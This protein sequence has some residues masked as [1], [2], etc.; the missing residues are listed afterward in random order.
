MR[1][2]LKNLLAALSIGAAAA[3]L[4][5]APSF[6]VPDTGRDARFS[7]G[8]GPQ[9][10]GMRLGRSVR[11]LRGARGSDGAGHG[12]GGP[13]AGHQITPQLESPPASR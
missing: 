11:R 3:G 1:G 9:D 10:R 5:A 2:F 8:P 12:P 13:V 4:Q 7:H 6:S